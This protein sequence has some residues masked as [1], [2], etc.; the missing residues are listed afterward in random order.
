MS[1]GTFGNGA[2]LGLGSTTISELTS[3]GLPGFSSDDIDVTTH[4]DSDRI[5]QFIKGLT[6]PGEIAFE[7]NMNYTDYANIFA[8]QITTSSFTA[9]ITVP[10]TPSV[11]VLQFQ[12][13]V[14]GLE[15][16]APHDEKVEM[17]G[18]LKV[19]GLPILTK[20]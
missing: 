5:R 7:G 1:T 19:S 6:D 16:T 11:T 13:Y 4:N 8:Q 17:S 15:S 12:S 3:I 18:T 9:T 14:K 20:V 10:T 2:A